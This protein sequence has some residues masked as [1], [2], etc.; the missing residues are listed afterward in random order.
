MDAASLRDRWAGYAPRE[1][2]ALV[3]GTLVIVATLLYA[4]VWFPLA[5][6][7]PRARLDAERA[8]RRLASATAAAT[9]AGTRATTPSRGP[10]D[11]AVRG[12]LARNG[13]SAGDATL[14]TAGTRASLTIPSIRFAT[15]VALVDGLARSDAV[16]VVDATITARVEPGRVRAELALS[17]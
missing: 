15:L 17:R 4:F 10:I 1:K 2:R 16:H 6:D 14:E 13:V 7:L 12:A 9:A 8:E 11:A 3:A 5:Q